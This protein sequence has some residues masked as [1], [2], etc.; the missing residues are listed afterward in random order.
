MK[1]IIKWLQTQL[2]K[3]LPD[4]DLSPLP[5]KERGKLRLSPE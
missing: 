4:W 3:A 5:G 2:V 1:S